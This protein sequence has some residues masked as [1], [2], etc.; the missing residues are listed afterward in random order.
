MGKEKK[1]KTVRQMVLKQ[2]KCSSV[3]GKYFRLVEANVLCKIPLGKAF[4]LI[5]KVTVLM[6]WVFDFHG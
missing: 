1:K 2:A 5:K 4:L 3:A 6:F